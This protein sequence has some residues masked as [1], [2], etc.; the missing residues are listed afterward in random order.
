MVKSRFLVKVL[1]LLAIA[2]CSG[3][4]AQEKT[5]FPATISLYK[6]LSDSE[7]TNALNKLIAHYNKLESDSSVFY[8]RQGLELFKQRNYLKGQAWMVLALGDYDDTHGNRASA[9]EKLQYALSLFSSQ[10][11]TTGIATASNIMGVIEGKQGNFPKSVKYFV[12]AER[13]FESQHDREGLMRTWLNLGLLNDY[14]NDSGN[15]FKY[16]N[17]VDSISRLLPLS[18]MLIKLYNNLGAYYFE[19]HDTVKAFSIMQKALEQ[20]KA[21]D[22]L[23]VRLVTLMNMG[24]MLYELGNKAAAQNNLQ[25]ALTLAQKY[26][27]PDQEANV[28]EDIAMLYAANQP[29]T[30]IAQLKTALALVRGTG[31]KIFEL[32]MLKGL[33][34]V[35]V[36][37]KNFDEADKYLKLAFDLND[38]LNNV[39]KAKEIANLTS[40]YE[41][42]QSNA[43]VKDL[44]EL[45]RN[46][47]F[48][49]NIIVFIAISL[50]VVMGI[51]FSY[52]RKTIGLNQKLEASS[53]EL[54]ELNNMKNKLFMVIGHDLRGPVAN[55][56]ALIDIIEEEVPMP[57]EFT[58]LL[59]S[60][61]D[62]ATITLETLDKLML[63]GK[64]AMTG[65]TSNP[66]DF[67]PKN[68]VSKNIELMNFVAHKKEITIH[69]NTPDGLS[70]HS[71]VGH[72]DFII[73]NLLSNAI[74]FSFAGG[75]IEVNA[76]KDSQIGVV[77]FSVRDF[78][79]GIPA[80]AK[81][82]L[83]SASVKSTYGTANEKG[84][85]IGLMLC[86]EFVTVD[87]GKIWVESEEGKGAT[88]YFTMKV[89]DAK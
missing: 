23:F 45:N 46:N 38:S 22:Y 15:T 4:W 17:K 60:L 79:A 43:R 66:V 50:I 47:T 63:L 9:T 61:K 26:H 11:D 68:Y 18:D 77:T 33:H 21:Q 19:K 36:R 13:L 5:G 37:Q 10:N 70:L 39:A 42:K 81:N 78:G 8:A 49:K 25:E 48:Q 83:F 59:H 14:A 85:G 64:A 71:D 34:E 40:L 56:P 89:S 31:N 16:Y 53:K 65:T 74:K 67:D 84:N 58:E 2:V 32:N 72:F 76:F 57:E 30:S 3:V 88:F 20:S 73:R 6:D 62:H 7:A 27:M 41:L 1:L 75:K 35:Y 55:I 80:G 54:E 82:N 44:E 86:K 51:L 28:L 24:Q 52:Y 87:G 12:D 69:D 29:D